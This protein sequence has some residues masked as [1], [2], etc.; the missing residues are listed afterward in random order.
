M[1]TSRWP[2]LSSSGSPSDSLAVIVANASCIPYYSNGCVSPAR[3]PL[4]RALPA[5]AAADARSPPVRRS[6]KGCARSM[7][8]SCAL[9]LV[10]KKLGITVFEVPLLPPLP[11]SSLLSSPALFSPP[12]PPPPSLYGR[13]PPAGSSSAT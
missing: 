7:P 5:A 4:A 6:L 10:A 8:T 3:G 9:D 11:V 13:C 1:T 12:S 2:L